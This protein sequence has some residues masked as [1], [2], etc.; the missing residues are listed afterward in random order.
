M[1]VV[2]QNVC[3]MIML[4]NVI[5]SNGNVRLHLAAQQI[6][7][8]RNLSSSPGNSMPHQT[9]FNRLLIQY[10]A[11][12]VFQY[13]LYFLSHFSNLNLILSRILKQHSFTCRDVIYNISLNGLR[14]QSRLEW[15][16]SDADREL[17][18]LKG[19]SESDCHNYLRVFARLE[20]GKIL[21]CGTNSYKPRCRHYAPPVP[22]TSANDTS[23]NEAVMPPALT[24]FGQYEIVRDVE[25]QGLCPYS[26]AHNSTYAFADGQLYSATVADFSGSD[27]LIYRENLRTEQY[28]LKQLNQPDFVGAFERNGYVLFFFREISMEFM[29]FGKAIYSRVGRICK[30]DKGG[31]YTLSKSWTT[32]LKARLNCSMPGDF[33]FYFDEIR[34]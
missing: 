10:S 33:P 17:C 28:D 3:S 8:V 9:I 31:P 7:Q 32:F 11:N 21:V 29:N 34:K 15:F 18:A 5:L 12:L 22:E 16:S 20:Q 26:P 19:K 2:R 25:A 27:P 4:K 1:M 14:E 23:E 30:K 13:W 6:W 24:S